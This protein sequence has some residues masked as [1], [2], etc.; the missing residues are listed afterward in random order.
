MTLTLTR[1]PTIT[2][3]LN[4]NSRARLDGRGDS[5]EEECG[6]GG[7]VPIGHPPN[8][9]GCERGGEGG[10]RGLFALMRRRGPGAKQEG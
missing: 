10:R 8:M 4:L 5:S 9:V 3:T 2:L 6:K 7:E 1:T